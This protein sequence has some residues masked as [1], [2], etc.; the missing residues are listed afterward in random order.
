MILVDAN[1][2]WQMLILIRER[3]TEIYNQKKG[4]A[5]KATLDA[6]GKLIWE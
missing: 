6:K 1:S 5:A 4:T 3:I 2:W